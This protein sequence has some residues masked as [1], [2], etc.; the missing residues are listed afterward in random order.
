MEAAS[1]PATA[2]ASVFRPPP[3]FNFP[4]PSFEPAAGPSGYKP[5]G[6]TPSSAPLPRPPATPVRTGNPQTP[7]ADARSSSGIYDA[8]TDCSM[9][10]VKVDPSESPSRVISDPEARE[11]FLAGFEGQAREELSFVLDQARRHKASLAEIPPDEDSAQVREI[12]RL[13]QAQNR[14]ES[15]LPTTSIS[16]RWYV[17]PKTATVVCGPR[18]VMFWQGMAFIDHAQV[19]FR[20]TSPEYFT[21]TPLSLTSPAVIRLL[22]SSRLLALDAASLSAPAVLKHLKLKKPF[23]HTLRSHN[24]TIFKDRFA[25]FPETPEL[26][27][28]IFL[29][30][31]DKFADEK[32]AKDLDLV[33]SVCKAGLPE[34]QDQGHWGF[35]FDSTPDFRLDRVDTPLQGKLVQ[36][37]P[38]SSEEGSY[39]QKT[40]ICTDDGPGAGTGSGRGD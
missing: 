10:S 20:Q 27:Q 32:I 19:E 25:R 23:D 38:A 13:I 2:A 4:P 40:S 26:C 31:E 12:K 17:P 35:L 15:D 21:F 37:P 6:V 24:I 34:N 9:V 30:A 33:R 7:H 1:Q 29:A 11:A 22:D 16:V 8:D 3:V 18:T 36:P 28:G 39:L 5:P 14:Q